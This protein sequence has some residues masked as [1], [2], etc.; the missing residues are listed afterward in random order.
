MI[1]Q[2]AR[3]AF[4]A[5]LFIASKGDGAT[6]QLSEIVRNEKIPKM[7][8]R[9]IL[10]GLKNS[11]LV[12]SFRGRAGGYALNRPAYKISFADIL[13]VTDGPIALSPCVSVTAY[14]RCEECFE[15]D[16]C[17]IRKV[18]LRVRN[19][20]ADIL[21][22]TSLADALAA[23]CTSPMSQPQLMKDIDVLERA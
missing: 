22:S 8:L 10:V 12:Y 15:E 13:R 14:G 7:F 6:V 21:E 20:T 1:S 9:L 18:L 3:Y 11:G 17:A 16:I 5:L 23:S 4:R 2:K 19:V